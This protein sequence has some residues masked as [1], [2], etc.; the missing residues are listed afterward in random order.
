LKAGV[1]ADPEHHYVEPAS[2]LQR[3]GEAC[4]FDR[5]FLRVRIELLDRTDSR[6]RGPVALEE[7]VVGAVVA[8]LTAVLVDGEG[9]D[10]REVRTPVVDALPE[11]VIQR[12]R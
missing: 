9:A 7:G 3:D 11:F 6:D 2:L 4:A 5:K 12:D 1:D 8:P 10:G